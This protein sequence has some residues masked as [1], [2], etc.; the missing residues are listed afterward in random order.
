QRVDGLILTGGGRDPAIYRLIDRHK[1]P[2]VVT[3][4]LDSDAKCPC[5]S[6]DNYAAGRIAMQHLLELGHRQIG[7][8]CGRTEVNDRARERRNAYEDSL[9]QAGISL[10]PELIY[11]RD[12]EYI[13]GKVAMRRLL[14]VPVPPTAVFAANDIQA[15][16]AIAQCRETGLS[17]PR[18]ISV[19]GFDDLPVAEF[20]EP[21]LTTIRVPAQRMGHVAASHLLQ[22]IQGDV[23]PQSE[24]LPVELMLRGTT[25]VHSGP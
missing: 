9:R 21:K 2:Y 23:L 20:I 15:I 24:V 8:I 3:W 6:F 10:D 16:G 11:E 7:L 13:E 17:I 18:D 14:E 19:I 5:I 25:S 22:M 4:R 1:I 12:F